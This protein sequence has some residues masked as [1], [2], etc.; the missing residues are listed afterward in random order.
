MV[1]VQ[2][3]KFHSFSHLIGLVKHL[4]DQVLPKPDP[5]VS[6]VLL[7]WMFQRESQHQGD[8]GSSRKGQ[9]NIQEKVIE[10]Y[11][12]KYSH[13]SSSYGTCIAS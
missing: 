3:V 8:Q 1:I 7:N 11:G 4:Y 6:T 2:G 13:N 5:V 12:R 10:L 9:F